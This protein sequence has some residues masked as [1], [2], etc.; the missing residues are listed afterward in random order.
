MMKSICTETTAN[1]MLT[2]EALAAHP[3][4]FRTNS[5]LLTITVGEAGLEEMANQ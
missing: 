1:T 4:A 3:R 5:I 2:G